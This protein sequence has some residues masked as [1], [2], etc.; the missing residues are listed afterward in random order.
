[1]PDEPAVTLRP[2]FGNLSAFVNGNMFAGLFGEDLFVRLPD[3]EAD[4]IRK[5]GG[6]DFA[7]M[8]GH[9][10]KGYVTVP[11]TWRSKIPATKGWIAASL[12]FARTLP[13][14]APGGKKAAAKK[15][16]ARK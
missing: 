12:A 14:K 4:A 13:P 10:M 15:P 5:Q 8:A 11:E 3:K 7:P 16:P 1:M 2:M 9:V 6:R